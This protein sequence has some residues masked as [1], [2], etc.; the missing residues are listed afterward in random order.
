MSVSQADVIRFI[1][2]KIIHQFGILETITIDQG[3]VFMSNK[4]KAFM[5]EYGIV[6][7]H[8]SSY[9]TQAND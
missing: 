2:R 5:Q 6:L 3:M 4:V 7:V 8:F 1:E 9:Y